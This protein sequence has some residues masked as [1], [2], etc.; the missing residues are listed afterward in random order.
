MMV[1]VGEG[2]TKAPRSRR[3]LTTMTALTVNAGYWSTDGT[4]LTTVTGAPSDFSDGY[5][6]SFSRSAKR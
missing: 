6:A 5:D 2:M 1:S 3:R 4:F